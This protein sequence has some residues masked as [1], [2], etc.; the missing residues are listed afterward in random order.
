MKGET[1]GESAV[2]GSADSE[3]RHRAEAGLAASERRDLRRRF[4]RQSGAAVLG[5]AVGVAVGGRAGGFHSG[6]VTAQEPTRVKS[7][8]ARWR[9]GAIGL[10]YQGSVITREATAFGDVVAVCDVDRHVREQARASFGSVATLFEDYRDLLGRS[11]IDVVLIGG[12][13]SLA[14]QN[15]G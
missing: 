6:S 13:G 2:P 12:A 4:L 11:D 10:R 8:N 14:R 15:G 9:I 1:R 3:M 7:P 5:A